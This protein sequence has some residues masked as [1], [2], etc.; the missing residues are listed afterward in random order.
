MFTIWQWLARKCLIWIDFTFLVQL[1]YCTLCKHETSLLPT[2]AHLS[3]VKSLSPFLEPQIIIKTPPIS[4]HGRG[5][6]GWKSSTYNSEL[7]DC[8]PNLISSDCTLTSCLVFSIK[9]WNVISGK[10]VTFFHNQK[11]PLQHSVGTVRLA[12]LC[13]TSQYWVI[14]MGVVW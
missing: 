5:K 10:N 3:V 2:S 1:I 6:G 9:G 11:S 14:N 4:H 8:I 12:N 7:S 13:Q